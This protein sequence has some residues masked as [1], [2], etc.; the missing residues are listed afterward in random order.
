MGKEPLNK[1]G[2]GA[3]LLPVKTDRIDCHYG[4]S[5]SRLVRHFQGIIN[6]NS[7]VPDGAFKLRMIRQ[8]LNRS[9]FLRPAI[10]PR[11]FSSPERL[12]TVSVFLEE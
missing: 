11:G 4:W 1:N 8:D 9:V 2:D 3:I 5:D 12:S 6:F 7:Q 10:D